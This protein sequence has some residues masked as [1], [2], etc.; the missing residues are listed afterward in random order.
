M[1][2]YKILPQNGLPSSFIISRKAC[3]DSWCS[4]CSLTISSTTELKLTEK[5]CIGGATFLTP[6]YSL[7]T[8]KTIFL[9]AMIWFKLKRRGA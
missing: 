7:Q 8:Q 4:R 3:E 1:H 5:P 9:A 2:Y 6:I